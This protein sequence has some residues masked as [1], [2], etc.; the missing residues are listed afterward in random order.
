MLSQQRSCGTCFACCVWLGV[1]PLKK[2]PGQSCKH[3]DGSIPDK[4]CT[5]YD[6]RPK[7]CVDYHCGWRMGIGP[8]NLRPDQSGVLVTLYPA[9]GDDQRFVATLHVI[10]EKKAGGPADPDS[11]LSEILALVLSTGCNDVR[12][13][14]GGERP[15]SPIV[16]LREG[17]IYRGV[18]LKP[19]HNK[20]EDMNFAE[21]EEPVGRYQIKRDEDLTAEDEA[22]RE[23]HRRIARQVKSG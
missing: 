21:E 7:C 22:K 12:I 6:K 1:G 15:G 11:R 18:V 9:E 4:R 19:D 3:L 17:K 16:H 8:D 20:F 13:V 23:L 14:S 5:I 10:D 2:W